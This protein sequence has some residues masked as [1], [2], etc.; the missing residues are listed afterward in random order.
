[1]NEVAGP[2]QEQ[3]SAV[4][5]SGDKS[6]IRCCKEQHCLGT[7][8]A[9]STNQGKLDVVKQEMVRTNINI[10]GTGELK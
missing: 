2:K 8:N 6:K 7:W 1:M 3:C 9:G 10:L 4:N 5:V